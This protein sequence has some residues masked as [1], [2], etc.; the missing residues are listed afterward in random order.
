MIIVIVVIWF[1][2]CP[3]YWFLFSFML[4]IDLCVFSPLRV[5]Y[6]IDINRANMIM[7]CMFPFMLCIDLLDIV[8]ANLRV[9]GLGG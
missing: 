9:G 7:S 6:I 3:L 1:D 4:G 2:V 5:G 8:F